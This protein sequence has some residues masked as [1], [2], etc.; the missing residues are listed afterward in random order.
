MDCPAPF[1]PELS[2]VPAVLERRQQATP[3]V[4]VPPQVPLPAQTASSHPE[5]RETYRAAARHRQLSGAVYG[6]AGGRGGVWGVGSGARDPPRRPYRN[7]SS[8]SR[9]WPGSPTAAPAARSFMRTSR[10]PAPS[11]TETGGRCSEAVVGLQSSSSCIAVRIELELETAKLVCW[12][13][14]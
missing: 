11:N 2:P 5:N 3:L 12:L 10:R 4:P 9:G 13:T 1:S 14:K 8:C 6:P 7:R